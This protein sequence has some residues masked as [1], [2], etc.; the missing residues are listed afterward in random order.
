MSKDNETAKKTVLGVLAD[1]NINTIKFALG[2]F[3]VS[4]Q[5]YGE[6]ADAI[7]KDKITVLVE[8]SLKNT[9]VQAI[10][11]NELK[12]QN[13]TAMYNLML[14]RDPDL[15][16]GVTD[17]KQKI[18]TAF[19]AMTGI[20]H[21]CTH[22]GFDARKLKKVNTPHNEGAAY[23]AGAMFAVAKMREMGGKPEKVFTDPNK[24]DIHSVAWSIALKLENA[25]DKTVA[26]A[27][28][29]ALSVEIGKQPEYKD[30]MNDIVPNDGVDQKW[31]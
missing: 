18:N 12:L 22:A 30:K 21:E 19:N 11:I 14:L 28:F 20:V 29:N 3:S 4:P 31:P 24:V 5:M 15:V 8:A 17:P 9:K 23:I 10:Y 1:K 25:K 2:D 27:D 7:K 6:V 16:G 13:G 26:K